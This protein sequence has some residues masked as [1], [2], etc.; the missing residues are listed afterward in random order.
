MVQQAPKDVVDKKDLDEAL[1]TIMSQP[2]L[3]NETDENGEP[4]KF[5]HC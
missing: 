3:V 1:E 5:P 4:C 2:L